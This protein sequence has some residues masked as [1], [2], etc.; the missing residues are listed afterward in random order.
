M[1]NV[2]LKVSELPFNKLI[3]LDLAPKD[4]DFQTSLPENTQYTNHLGTVH[5][6]AMLAV[7]E[8]ASGAF[9]A[10]HFSSYSGV[11]PVVRRLEAKFRKPAV[12]Q[13]S[14]RCVVTPEILETWK[15]ELTNRGR[16]S[17]AI[18]VEVVDAAG[19]IVMSAPLNGLFRVQPNPVCNQ[20]G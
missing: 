12:G 2:R 1:S 11:V 19:I 7:A 10:R 3:G 14:A 15:G 13:I 16:L 6:S 18:P 9:L 8:A 5:A 20:M 17:I 4:S